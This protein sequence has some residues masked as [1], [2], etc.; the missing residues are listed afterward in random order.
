M[1]RRVVELALLHGAEQLQLVVVGQDGH[2]VEEQRPPLRLRQLAR[3]VEAVVGAAVGADRVRAVRR[4]DLGAGGAVEGDERLVAP[5]A[6]GVDR[7]GQERL[8]GPRLADDQDRGAAHGDR[9]RQLDRLPQRRVAADDAQLAGQLLRPGRRAGGGCEGGGGL[10]MKVMV[11][12]AADPAVAGGRGGGHRQR[13]QRLRH[14]G[15]QLGRRDR[16]P[17]HGQGAQP[18]R[19]LGPLGVGGREEQDH[20]HLAVLAAH[21][22][23]QLQGVGIRRVD[24]GHHQVNP[25]PLHQ[26][27]RHP[28]VGRLVDLVPQR[29]QHR[30]QQRQGGRLGMHDQESSFAHEV[31]L[32]S[33]APAWGH[34]SG[35]S[36]LRK[37]RVLNIFGPEPWP[38]GAA[39]RDR[40]GSLSSPGVGTATADRPLGS[41]F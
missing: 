20:R 15:P 7:A 30:R 27:D 41:S 21:V 34:D 8:A 12:V 29:H 23:E 19:L 17:Q 35:A 1:D 5:R 26:A 33:N 36:S 14:R 32:S 39:A 28:V 13:P 37:W 16:I 4:R 2:L 6:E 31:I 24:A 3:P 38:P 25:A 11:M 40:R 10:M 9:R 18:Q 22:G